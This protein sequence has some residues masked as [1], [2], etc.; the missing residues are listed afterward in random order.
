MAVQRIARLIEGHV[1]GQDDRQVG[2]RHRDG[3]AGIAMNDR[4][5]T[6]PVT[7]AGNAPVAQAKINLPRAGIC[8]LDPVGNL[9]L[10]GVHF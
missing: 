3:S 4:N 8:A 6:A 7:L 1:I 5:R 9:C 10:C 2:G